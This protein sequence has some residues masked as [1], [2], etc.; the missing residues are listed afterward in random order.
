MTTAQLALAWVHHQA[1]ELMCV[2]SLEP[3]RLKT[4]TRTLEPYLSSLLLKRLLSVKGHRYGGL[5]STW[6]NSEIPSLSSGMVT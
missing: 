5:T 6:K 3:L 4:S 2:S 1:R